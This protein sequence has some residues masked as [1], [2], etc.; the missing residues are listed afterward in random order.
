MLLAYLPFA[1]DQGV[2]DELCKASPPWPSATGRRTWPWSEGAGRQGADQAG[3][4]RR[5]AGPVGDRPTAGRRP[6]LLHDPDAGVRLRVAL[7]LV[8]QKEK[9]VV[10]VLIDLLA[11]LEPDQSWRREEVLLRLAGDKAPQVATGSDIAARK[12]ARDA[13][14]DWYGKHKEEVDL[15]KLEEPEPCSATRSSSSRTST[16][17]R[18]SAAS[19]ARCWS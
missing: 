4:R 9:Q 11:D 13:W 7:A 10:P 2:V 19:P 8:P 14:R 1:V 6:K 5:G 15:A 12:A 16:A 3:R 17:W 18:P